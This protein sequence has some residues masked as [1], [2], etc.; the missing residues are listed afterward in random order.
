[1]VAGEVGFQDQ[2]LVRKEVVPKK[3]NEIINRLNRTKKECEPDLKGEQEAFEA[4]MRR[5]KNAE[6][7]QRRL[8]EKAT[9]E[10]HKRQK[11]L[12]SY[13]TLMQEENMVTSKQLGEKYENYDEYEEDFM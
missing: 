10:E 4:E 1:M 3:I 5:K 8:E 9:R 12:R 11:E 7:H 2:K 13:K 6:A